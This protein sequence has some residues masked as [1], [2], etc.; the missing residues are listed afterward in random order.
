MKRLNIRVSEMHN[1]F[2]DKEIESLGLTKQAYIIFLIEN[3]RKK[4]RRMSGE[5][6]H[7]DD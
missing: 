6:T 4:Q 1:D 2:L 7:N 5:E 3:E